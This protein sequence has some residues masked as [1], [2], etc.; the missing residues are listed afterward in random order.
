MTIEVQKPVVTL[1]HLDEDTSQLDWEWQIRG[2]KQG[3]SQIKGR[4]VVVLKKVIDL[5]DHGYRVR[6]VESA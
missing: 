5:R 1:R 4:R 6:L 2:V 3:P